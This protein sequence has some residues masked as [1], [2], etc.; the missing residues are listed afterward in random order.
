ML[1]LFVLLPS[2]LNYPFLITTVIIQ[3]VPSFF[4]HIFFC[5]FSLSSRSFHISSFDL[6]FSVFIYFLSLST[7]LSSSSFSLLLFSFFKGSFFHHH[8]AY[9]LSFFLVFSQLLY[10]SIVE[11]ISLF[12]F[13]FSCPLFSSIIIIYGITF[14]LFFLGCLLFFILEIE[15]CLNWFFLSPSP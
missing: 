6:L 14:F 13:F 3:I 15:L 10:F 11:A 9:L 8:H 4:S 1:F 5:S 7:R 12:F 2:F